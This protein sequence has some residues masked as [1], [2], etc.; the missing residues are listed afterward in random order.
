M[1]DDDLRGPS[2]VKEDSTLSYSNDQEDDIES[3]PVEVV[4]EINL[5]YETESSS[6]TSRI[7]STKSKISI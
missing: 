4:P 6:G 5:D 2:R 7:H 3:V 1:W